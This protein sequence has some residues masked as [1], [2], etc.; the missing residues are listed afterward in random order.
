MP[1]RRAPLETM[2]LVTMGLWAGTLG[3]AGASAAIIFPMMRELDPTLTPYAL[4]TE[5]HWRLAA[6]HV[7]ASL[8]FV[9]DIIQ[10]FCAALACLS[11]VLMVLFKCAAWPDRAMAARFIVI[12][13]LLA[14]LS[15]RFFILAPRMD[16]SLAEYRAAAR[17][18][19]IATATTHANA[20]NDDHP[21]ASNVMSATFVLVLT[22]LILGAWHASS[23]WSRVSVPTRGKA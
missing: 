15:Y 12:T 7:A 18:G 8:F 9:A 6:G 13:L 10:L 19:D 4:Y 22:G 23:G 21:A 17:L 20:F 11:L 3:M 5:P 14:L 1:V 2:H 16:Q